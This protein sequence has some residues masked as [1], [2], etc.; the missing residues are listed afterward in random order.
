MHTS[1]PS[2]VF[3]GHD[4][5]GVDESVPYPTHYEAHYPKTK[6]LAE[7]RVRAANSGGLATVALRP[8]LIW[9]PGDNH[10][11]PRIIAKAKAGQLRRIGH[12]PNFVDSLYI[13]NAA[14][15]H[16]LAADRLAPGAPVAGKVYFISQGEPLPVWELINRILAT[17]DLPPVNRTVPTSI[18]VAA[19]AILELV[20]GVFRLA[21]EPRMTR[22]LA[23]ELSTAHW[24]NLTAARRDLGYAPKVSLE[25]GLRRLKASF[26]EGA[27]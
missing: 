7:Q 26:R 19:G 21:G 13:D 16:L 23:R 1:S 6:A 11:V 5:E 22:F 15:A 24:F 9:G 20:H 4:L 3:N 2:V 27:S 10:L 25:E 8:H 18:A 12:R 14:A 17:A